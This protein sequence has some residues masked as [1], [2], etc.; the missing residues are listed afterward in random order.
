MSMQTNFIVQSY[1]KGPRGKLIAD[2]PFVAKDVAHARRTAERMAASSP[3][4]IAFAN[5]SD[6]ETGD[7]E[8]PKL[9][10]AHGDPLPPE[11][12]EMERV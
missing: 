6:A 5:T 10:Y 11:V 8:E 3:M 1:S 12:E 2:T 9:I 4:V 7:F